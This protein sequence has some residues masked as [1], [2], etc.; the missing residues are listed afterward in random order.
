M[1]DLTIRLFLG[2]LRPFKRLTNKLNSQSVISFAWRHKQP[3]YFSRAYW[4]RIPSR[5]PCQ[6]FPS[7]NI[8]G[9]AV[10]GVIGRRN[11]PMERAGLLPIRYA[12]NRIT[13]DV[14]QIFFFLIVLASVGN[15]INRERVYNCLI[16]IIIIS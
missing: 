10:I 16:E 2:R 8:V 7:P 14:L 1:G 12:Y 15:C 3:G 4:D 5:P 6:L 11:V 9:I 13:P